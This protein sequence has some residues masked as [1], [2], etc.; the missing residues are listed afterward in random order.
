MSLSGSK[1]VSSASRICFG[2]KQS[3]K[4]NILRNATLYERNFGFRSAFKIKW[5]HVTT[6]IHSVIP[7]FD[8]F[9]HYSLTKLSMHETFFFQISEP[10][11]A[12]KGNQIDP[13][14]NGS[15]FQDDIVKNFLTGF[16]PGEKI[17]RGA[18]LE[19]ALA[20]QVFRKFFKI[21]RTKI[22]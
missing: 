18:V 7:D 21:D 11:K 12:A 6:R 5:Q 10:I 14:S 8:I 4:G 19:F 9:P 20:D 16:F 13:F 1:R 15:R 17:L 3:I 2:R 22:R